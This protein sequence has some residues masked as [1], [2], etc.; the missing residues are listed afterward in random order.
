MKGG[1]DSVADMQKALREL[2]EERVPP[3]PNGD[4]KTLLVFFTDLEPDDTMAVAQLWQRRVASKV[5]DCEP[6]IIFPVDFNDKDNK[7]TIFDKKLLVAG[8]MLGHFTY[9]IVPADMKDGQALSP[10]RQ[11]AVNSRSSTIDKICQQL[12]SFQGECID[13]FVMAPGYG[14]LDAI[15]GKLRALN[16]WPLKAKLRVSI[17]SGS[18]NMRGMKP[19]DVDALK[20]FVSKAAAPLLDVA[21]FSFFGGKDCHDWTDSLTTFALPNFAKHLSNAS[22]MLAAALK[23][24]ND[25]MNEE[26]ISPYKSSLFRGSTLDDSDNVKL[27]GLKEMF[28]KEGVQVYADALTSDEVMFAKVAGFKKSTL[29]AFAKGGCDSPLCDQLL[30]LHEWLRDEKP[31][32]LNP[33]Q[34]GTWV[35]DQEKG[36]TKIDAGESSGGVPGLQPTLLKAKDEPALLEM[37]Y[38]LEEH[39]KRHIG[40]LRLTL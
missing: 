39:L 2:R 24:F 13:F 7:G 25:E 28:D 33:A 36:F 27:S 10:S 29:M 21:K 40:S 15:L 38:A 30:F 18:Y 1:S 4:G 31:Q 19:G 14:H 12:V 9:N 34:P 32:Y 11:A 37:R 35:F 3:K 22:P 8:L 26:L 20:E 5:L 16:A 17:Y 23:L 6:L